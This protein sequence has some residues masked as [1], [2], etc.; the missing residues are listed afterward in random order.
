MKKFQYILFSLL[1]LSLAACQQDPEREPSPVFAGTAIYFPM[2]NEKGLEADPAEGITDHVVT[3]AR[4]YADEAAD[5][6]LTVLTNTDGIF[7]VPASVHFNQGDTIQTFNIHFEGLQE[8]ITYSLSITVDKQYINPYLS[9]SAL[10]EM[11]MTNISWTPAAEKAVIVEGFIAGVFGAKAYAFYCDYMQASLSDG[12]KMFRF[13][14][15]YHRVCESDEPDNFGIWDAYP[16]M[17]DEDLLA[18]NNYHMQVNVSADGLV[19]IPPFAMGF[20]WGYGEEEGGSILGIISDEVDSYDYGHYTDGVIR[21]DDG[22]IYMYDDGYYVGAELLIY[23]SAEQYQAEMSHIE[24]Y[25]TIEWTPVSGDIHQFSSQA[26]PATASDKTLYKAVDIDPTNPESEYKNLY[27]LGDLYTEGFGLAFYINADGSMDIPERQPT[28]V[29][30]AGLDIFM[31]ATGEY[32]TKNLKG[33]D[34]HKI[35]LS[36]QLITKRQL[37][38]EKGDY[39][40]EY[41]EVFFYGEKEPVWTMSDYI[42]EGSFIADELDEP[43]AVTVAAGN[44]DTLLITG[45]DYAAEAAVASY[46]DQIIATYDADKQAMVIRAQTLSKV[47]LIVGDKKPTLAPNL[48]IIKQGEVTESPLFLHY[49]YDGKITIS[50]P[51]DADGMRIEALSLHLNDYTWPALTF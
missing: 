40:N 8:G 4:S 2:A 45:L 17:Y 22:N 6:T 44:I 7:T 12:R 28:G 25:N 24:D 33:T 5:Y 14:N 32:T 38:S 48:S 50:N 9:E 23:L 41:K 1:V 43:I 15:P 51:E 21:F 29:K 30:F 16:E 42:G 35:S 13:I 11:S 34:I 10:Y 37:E 31:S 36:L 3:I 49:D 46:N 47:K 39:L 18:G 20:D 26:F 27:M 19:T